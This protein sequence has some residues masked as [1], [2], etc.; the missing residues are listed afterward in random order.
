[1]PRLTPASKRSPF[2]ARILGPREQEPRRLR[3][4]IQLLLTLV[5]VST[6]VVGAG[7]VFVINNFAVPAPAPNA[8]MLVAL[9]IGVPAYV[10]AAAVV[11]VIWGTSTSLRALRWATQGSDVVPTDSPSS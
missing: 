6:N 11:G 8:G 9:A 4:R 5:L 3:I 1:M 7:V 2:G 10:V